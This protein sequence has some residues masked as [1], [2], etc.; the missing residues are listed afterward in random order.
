MLVES[1]L[2]ALDLTSLSYH[3]NMEY[4]SLIFVWFLDLAEEPARQ[5]SL[6][7]YW[8]IER[9]ELDEVSQKKNNFIIL[10]NYWTNS[11]AIFFKMILIALKSVMDSKK[12]LLI[13]PDSCIT[14]FPK[15]YYFYNPIC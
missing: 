2:T 9:S 4:N 7:I 6:Y 1:T 13:S 15:V 3:T 12:G 11:N 14:C 5:K 8:M 10:K